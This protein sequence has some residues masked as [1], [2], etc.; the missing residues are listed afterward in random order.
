MFP[1]GE[2]N[3]FSPPHRVCTGSGTIRGWGGPCLGVKRPGREADHSR[4][5]SA[6]VQNVRSSCLHTPSGNA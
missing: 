2:G 4:L 6:E 1:R 3:S 5:S